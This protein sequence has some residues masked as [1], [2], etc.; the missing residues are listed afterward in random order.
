[1]LPGPTPGVVG[2]P[3]AEEPLGAVAGADP[4]SAGGI[5]SV[6]LISSN[7]FKIHISL[8]KDRD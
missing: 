8:T 4:P 3:L 2:D 7:G 5:S 6:V 1:M